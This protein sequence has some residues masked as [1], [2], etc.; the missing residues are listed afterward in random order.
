MMELPCRKLID[1]FSH[2]VVSSDVT[3]LTTRENSKFPPSKS[4]SALDAMMARTHLMSSAKAITT[5]PADRDNKGRGNVLKDARTA[6]SL[7]WSQ[8]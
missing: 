2:V 8:R 7:S 3:G 4:Q 6:I 1:I 5:S